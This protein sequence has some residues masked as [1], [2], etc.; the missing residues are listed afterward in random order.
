MSD[1][2]G[3]ARGIVWILFQFDPTW[4]FALNAPLS[5]NVPIVLLKQPGISI[6]QSF[7]RLPLR[8]TIFFLYL[9]P[10]SLCQCSI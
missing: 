8:A 9:K 3:M 1:G 2:D 10:S 6:N 7:S 4:V 5:T